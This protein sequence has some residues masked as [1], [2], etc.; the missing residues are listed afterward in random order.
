[1]TGG[2]HHGGGSPKKLSD[3]DVALIRK[4]YVPP[5]KRLTIKEI[6]VKFDVSHNVIHRIVSGQG[7]RRVR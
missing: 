1:M 5:P 7:Y 2:G 4:L 3:E 6:A